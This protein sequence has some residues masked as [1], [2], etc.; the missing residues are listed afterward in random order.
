MVIKKCA[1]Y[2]VYAAA[3]AMIALYFKST[4]LNIQKC[5]ITIVILKAL[6]FQIQQQRVIL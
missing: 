6:F 5:I 3:A 1:P 4:Q 2:I